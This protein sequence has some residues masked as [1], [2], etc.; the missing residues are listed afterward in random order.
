MIS[1]EE[2][3]NIWK[4]KAI[5]IRLQVNFCYN[6]IYYERYTNINEAIAREK[7]LKGWKRIKKE[8]LIQTL[9]PIGIFL[10]VSS[11]KI[12]RSE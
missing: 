8:A 5:R 1:K 10:T 6:L 4:I 2:L 9:N 7:A 12:L 11:N 3:Q